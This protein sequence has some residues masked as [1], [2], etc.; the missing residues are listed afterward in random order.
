MPFLVTVDFRFGG[1]FPGAR[2][3]P[4]VL[5]VVLVP[6]EALSDF[7]DSGFALQRKAEPA[8]ALA[9]YTSINKIIR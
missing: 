9:A 6:K 2:P 1:R 7:F 3:K 4:V 5:A 8:V